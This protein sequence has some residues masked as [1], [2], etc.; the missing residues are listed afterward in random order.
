MCIVHDRLSRMRG[1]PQRSPLTSF[2]FLLHPV[3]P[4]ARRS[5]VIS[6]WCSTFQHAVPC[7]VNELLM[8]A[9]ADA[10]LPRSP[11]HDTSICIVV[12]MSIISELWEMANSTRH[13]EGCHETTLRSCK[14]SSASHHPST[15]LATTNTK[16]RDAPMHTTTPTATIK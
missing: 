12:Q 1:K 6:G 16:Y 3:H 11:A 10:R 14:T 13:E 4:I 5:P 8:C 9:A 7:T 2:P 15:S